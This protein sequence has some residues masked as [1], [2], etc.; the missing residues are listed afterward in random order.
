MVKFEELK[1][2]DARF[3]GISLAHDLTPR[4]REEVKK[5]IDAAKQ[6]HVGSS[7]DGPE[8]YWF[9]VAGLGSRMRVGL[10]DFL[11]QNTGDFCI[12]VTFVKDNICVSYYTI[13][14]D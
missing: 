3:K 13:C 9:R 10:P 1:E 5:L 12:S 8:N 6:D 2:A 4:Q 14:A 7:S 11:Q